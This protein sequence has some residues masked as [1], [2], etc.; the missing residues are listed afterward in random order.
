MIVR[1]YM[2]SGVQT[3]DP[4]T[5]PSVAAKLMREKRIRRLIVSQAGEVHG[6]VC[7]RDLTRAAERVGTSKQ[8]QRVREI[9]KSPVISV[10]QDD[11]IEKAARLMTK[12]HI[13]SLA[14]MSGAKLM[15]IITE[16]DIFR[17][18][19][20]VMAGGGNS[21]RITFD[22]TKGDQTLEFLISKC[23]SMGV[24]LL[25]YLSFEDGDRL[26][27]VARVRGDRTKDFVDDLWDSGEVVVNVIYLK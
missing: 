20:Q 5:K 24:R 12:H 2:T 22:I 19:T 15:G 8:V 14:V 10:G 23:K 1:M 4:D 26:M 3:I 13:G 6:I 17:A 21:A 11:P 7:A 27:A 16:S 9:M 25:S 18:L